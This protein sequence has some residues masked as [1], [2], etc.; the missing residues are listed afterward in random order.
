M[1]SLLQ[2]FVVTKQD[3]LNTLKETL[4]DIAKYFNDINFYV[5]YNSKINFKEVY[6][7]YEDNVSD[8][9]FYNDLTKDWGKIVQ[10]M[11]SEIESKY[12]FIMPED[13]ILYNNDKSYFNNLIEELNKYDCDHMI[14]HRIEYVK[15][16]G[17]DE[18]YFDRWDYVMD[19]MLFAFQSK[20]EDWEEQ[21][22]SN[23]IPG[24]GNGKFDTKAYEAYSNRIN[25][26]F[27]LFG[28]YYN[29]LWD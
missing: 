15:N 26:G 25:K 8:L 28:K 24:N 3:R 9:I 10:S 1:I 6:S 11:I 14:M 29:G 22:F 4:P 13:Y 17:T 19:E 18:K 7:L 5:N 27:K 23:G 12:I 21:F 2:N 16:Y 20:L